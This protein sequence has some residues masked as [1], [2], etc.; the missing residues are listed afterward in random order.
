MT[1]SCLIVDDEPL[2]IK[3]IAS[4]VER[5]PEL[6]LKSTCKSAFEALD[7]IRNEPVDL[8]FLDIQMPG[9]TGMEMIRSMKNPPAFIFTTAHREY[10]VEAYDVDAIDYLLKPVSFHRYLQ[11]VNKYLDYL[12]SHETDPAVSKEKKTLHL[13]ADRKTYRIDTG[14]I[15]FIEGLKDYVRVFIEGD[16]PLITKER[17]S[18]MEDQLVDSGFIR[19]HK[20]YLVPVEKITSFSSESVHVSD[21]EIPIG[22]T[23]KDGVLKELENL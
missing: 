4:Y 11:A 7:I 9:L 16:K 2:A 23:Y 19:I 5:T 20:S 15:L 17:M 1:K 18:D 22:R 21:H 14:K 10:A 12:K 13:R 6:Y 3:V 8:V